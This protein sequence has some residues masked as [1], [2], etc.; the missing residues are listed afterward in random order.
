MKHR[1]FALI[2]VLVLALGLTAPAAALVDYD[3]LSVAI[4]EMDNERLQTHGMTTLPG[5]SSQYGFDLR[6]DIVDAIEGEDLH[7]YAC[8]V[9]ESEGYGYGDNKDGSLL[10]IQVADLGGS[11]DIM[12][13]AVIGEGVGTDLLARADSA[14][15]FQSLDMTMMGVG[16][17]YVSAGVLCADAVD[18]Y[19]GVMGILLDQHFNAATPPGDGTQGMSAEQMLTAVRPGYIMDNAGLLPQDNRTALEI[20][21]EELA[22]EYGCGVY[23]LTVD[24]MNGAERREF[25]EEY[26]K[27]ND[28]GVG[29]YRNGILFL[30]CMDTRDYVTVTYGCNPDDPTEY[31]TGILAFTDAGITAMEEE[32]VPMLSADDYTGAFETYLDTCEDYLGYYAEHGEGKVAESS[33][34]VLLR[35][36]I[37]VLVPLLIALAVCLVLRSQMKTAKAATTAEEYIP[38]E[39]FALTARRDQFVHTSRHREKIETSSDSGSGSS[40]SSSGFG[41]SKGGKF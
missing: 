20:R 14:L 35:L 6:V 31:G 41:G 36:A 10:M 16:L 13:Y 9:Y 4:S 1:I 8:S 24:S 17:D 3:Y 15:L 18:A 34:S 22:N 30:V 26:Y 32:I 39:S 11:V 2:L 21:A 28:L 25:A 19:V 29:D 12:G 37:V 23:A 7:E 5:M 38:K 27:K 33:G 40:V